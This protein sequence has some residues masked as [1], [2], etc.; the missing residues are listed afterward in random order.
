MRPQEGLGVALGTGDRDLA[1]A[2]RQGTREFCTHGTSSP[3]FP[4]GPLPPTFLAVSLGL[5]GREGRTCLGQARG[6]LVG[7]CS[8]VLS[9]AGWALGGFQLGLV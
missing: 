3:P 2:S 1:V 4:L 9:L 5:L 8:E 7:A 6:V